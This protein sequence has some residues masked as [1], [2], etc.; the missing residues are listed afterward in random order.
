[1]S[2]LNMAL[3]GST[4]I[5]RTW[6]AALRMGEPYLGEPT[7]GTS[8][9]SLGC[10]WGDTNNINIPC[11]TGPCNLLQQAKEI[12]PN[13]WPWILICSEMTDAFLNKVQPETWISLKHMNQSG[14]TFCIF[15]CIVVPQKQNMAE[16]QQC[17]IRWPLGTGATRLRRIPSSL[18]PGSSVWMKSSC[19]LAFSIFVIRILVFS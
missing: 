7:W 8:C 11:L 16:H 2:W 17:R 18:C 3:W 13:S 10:S 4:D 5:W 15:C 1:M 9:T 6:V 12:T 14:A 19:S